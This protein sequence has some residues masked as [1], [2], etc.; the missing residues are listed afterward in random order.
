M[1]FACSTQDNILIITPE[2]ASLDVHSASSFKD[3]LVEF[4]EQKP[5]KDVVLDLHELQFIDSSGLGS[6]LSLLRTVQRKG[7]RLKLA[8]ITKPVR[9]TLELVSMH[10]IFEIFN[11]T[12]EAVRSFD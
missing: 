7:G 2:G 5:F 9:T 8:S 10:K 3:Q 4:L 11:T 1:K 12:D 6:L